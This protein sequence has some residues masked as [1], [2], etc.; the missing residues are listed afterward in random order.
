M[1]GSL[2][3][4]LIGAVVWTTGNAKRAKAYF[5]ME[6]HSMDVVTMGE[7]AA[8]LST[9]W[10]LGARGFGP[11]LFIEPDRPQLHVPGK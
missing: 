1:P 4:L 10:Q 9:R 2:T 6:P 3:A 11:A 8:S 7:I 5:D